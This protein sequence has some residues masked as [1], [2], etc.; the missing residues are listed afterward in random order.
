M[1][2]F[3]YDWT[4]VYF[5]TVMHNGKLRKQTACFPIHST[6]DYGTDEEF[7]R[8]NIIF[9]EVLMIIYMY[10]LPSQ[11]TILELIL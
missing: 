4:D 1:V 9:V 8:L 5:A 7:Q 6:M 2:V 11:K 10:K 3:S